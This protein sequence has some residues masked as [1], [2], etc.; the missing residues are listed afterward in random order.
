MSQNNGQSGKEAFY[1][2]SL[3]KIEREFDPENCT[4]TFE[5]DAEEEY[6]YVLTDLGALDRNFLK[7]HNLIAKWTFVAQN[8]T[9]EITPTIPKDIVA[10]S[11]PEEL[12]SHIKNKIIEAAVAILLEQKYPTG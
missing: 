6:K 12:Q 10:A 7:E 11:T 9:T 5:D 2:E 4:I 3:E 1:H 8:D